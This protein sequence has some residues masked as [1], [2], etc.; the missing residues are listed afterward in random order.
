MQEQE[1]KKLLDKYLDESISEQ[2]LELLEKFKK[3]LKK[4]NKEPHFK[5]ESHKIAIKTSLWTSIQEQTKDSKKRRSIIWKI[6]GVAAIFLGLL[7]T[8]Y[9]YLERSSANTNFVIPEN[10]ITLQ[11]ENGDVKVINEN[12][13][14]EVLDTNGNVVGKQ[15]GKSLKYS[16]SASK[17]ELAYNTLTVPRGKTFQLQLSDGTVAHLNAGSSIQYPVQFIPGSDRLVLITGE[18]YLNVAK[19]PEHPFIVNT[20][21]LNVRVLGTQFNVSAYPEDE[22]TEVVLVEGAVSLYTE[23][24]EYG[25]EKNVYLKPGFKGSFDKA[26]NNIDTSEVITSLYT[27][28]VNGKL[29]FRNMTF[30]NIMKKLERHYDVTIINNNSDLTHEEFNANFGNEPIEDVLLELK[31]NYGIEYQFLNDKII[32]E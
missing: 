1:F 10:A 20:N 31:A 12:G 13:Q 2:E 6:S 9:F 28:W 18:A 26:K 19:D 25:S 29:V 17:T 21:G 7:T 24:E 8:G 32:I 14:V 22:T 4:A 27:S 11:L 23:E 30:N 15:D 16:D 5:N 3:E